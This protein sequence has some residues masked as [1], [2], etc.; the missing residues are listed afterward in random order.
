MLRTE[1]ITVHRLAANNQAK[2]FSFARCEVDQTHVTDV[3][4]EVTIRNPLHPDL[5]LHFCENDMRNLIE[6]GF[7]ALPS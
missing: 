5:V 4:Y 7:K 1:G 2:G 3:L 6:Q